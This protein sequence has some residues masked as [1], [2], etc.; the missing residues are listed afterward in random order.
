MRCKV[1]LHKPK[2]NDDIRHFFLK[3]EHLHL[4]DKRKIVKKQALTNIKKKAKETEASSGDIIS[5]SLKGIKKATL[6]IMPPPKQL[7]H[8]VSR[9]RMDPEI[10]S[11]PNKLSDMEL[12]EKFCKLDSGEKFLLYDSGTIENEDKSEKRLVMFGTNEN[13]KFLKQ[14]NEFCMDGTFT[15]TPKLFHQL[16]TIHGM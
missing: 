2:D 5:E 9:T 16:Y 6:A 7:Q 13:L 4:P 11:N 3:G 12:S 10:T 14:C 1:K 15:V 8:L